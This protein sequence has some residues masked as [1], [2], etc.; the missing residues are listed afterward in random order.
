MLIFRPWDDIPSPSQVAIDAPEGAI[1]CGDTLLTY[2]TGGHIRLTGLIAGE[3]VTCLPL[4]DLETGQLR[5]L[6]EHL[7]L[8]TEGTQQELIDRIKEHL[9]I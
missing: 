3:D 8:S 2:S 4:A 7:G 6:G 5:E 1:Y 9:N